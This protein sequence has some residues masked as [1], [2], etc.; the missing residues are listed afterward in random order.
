LTTCFKQSCEVTGLESGVRKIRMGRAAALPCPTTVGRRCRAAQTSIPR[1][2]DFVHAP[3]IRPVLRSF[4]QF[5]P[6]RILADVLPLLRVTLT[7]PQPM[8]K[9]A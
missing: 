1:P 6:H 4:H 8:M 7:V 2:T 9:T 5:I 3:E